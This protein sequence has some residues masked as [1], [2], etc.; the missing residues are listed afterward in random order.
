MSTVTD[1]AAG[2]ASVAGQVIAVVG[3]GAGIGRA[4]ALLL[5][6]RGARVACLDRDADSCREVV[7]QIAAAGGHAVPFTLDVGVDEQVTAAIGALDGHFGAVHGLV[8]CAGI[9]GVTGR[10]S[11][12]VDPADFD[13]V[14]RVNLRGAFL[15]SRAVIPVMLRQGYG[16]LLQVA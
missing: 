14:C 9:A 8:N 3:A 7:G 12:E 5:A 6:A 11:H 1:V 4:A 10:P 2:G 16:R 15:L 13:A